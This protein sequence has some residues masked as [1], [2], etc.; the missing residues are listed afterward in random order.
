MRFLIIFSYDGSKYFGFQ[1]QKNQKT[2]QQT[3]A[4]TLEK[5]NKKPVTVTPSG[6]TDTGV[7]A[8]NQVAHFDLDINIKTSALKK[9]LNTILPPDIYV[10]KVQKKANFHA[11]F[12]AIK[13]EYVYFI[14]TGTYN[15]FEKDYVWQLNKKLDVVKMQQ[16][17]QCFLGTHD[18]SSFCKKGKEDDCVRIIHEVV[19]K[20]QGS[21][22]KISIVGSG[23]LRYM[24]RNMVGTLTEVG[25][26]KITPD[27]ITNILDS[28]NRCQAGIK[29]PACGLYLKK[30]YYD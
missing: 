18:F 13:K 26:E 11:R 25:L 27:A 29:A 10:K 2:V 1:K 23:F 3:L 20:K 7:H 21:K 17:S 22:I 30:V 6:R 19:V 8:Y 5:I 28:K 12:D 24:V 9:A 15:V 14:N 16:A 4:D